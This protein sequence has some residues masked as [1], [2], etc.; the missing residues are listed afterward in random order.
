MPQERIITR[1]TRRVRFRPK[2]CRPTR[3]LTLYA[4]GISK[5]IYIRRYP[6][7]DECGG[8]TSLTEILRF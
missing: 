8:V 5:H 2:R 6:K 4:N 7:L 3:C 1:M